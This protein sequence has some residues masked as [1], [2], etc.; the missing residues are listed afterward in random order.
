MFEKLNFDKKIL[1]KI[2]GILVVGV[3]IEITFAAL[4][5]LIYSTSLLQ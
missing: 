1:R 5:L 3:F 4:S 2:L